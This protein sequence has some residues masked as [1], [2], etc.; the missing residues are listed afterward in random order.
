MPTGSILLQ[1]KWSNRLGPLP[2]APHIQRTTDFFHD[3]R[4]VLTNGDTSVIFEIVKLLN[5]SL[6]VNLNRQ[7]IMSSFIK[8]AFRMWEEEVSQ[9]IINRFTL[10]ELSSLKHMTMASEYTVSTTINPTSSQFQLPWGWIARILTFF[11]PMRK[12]IDK[13][14]V[15]LNLTNQSKN[16]LLLKN[17]P[18]ATAAR[19]QASN[20]C[21]MPPINNQIGI[22]AVY[23]SEELNIWTMFMKRLNHSIKIFY[24]S[25][26]NMI[27]RQ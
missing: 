8:L 10:V 25:I 2:G 18:P 15:I 9:R 5:D 13:I 19:L 12:H 7:A 17:P 26:I 1:I 20:Y 24:S 22:G 21:N 11:T 27:I 23:R 16:I 6:V 4:E 3:S 14:K